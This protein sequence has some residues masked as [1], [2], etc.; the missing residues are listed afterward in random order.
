MEDI[1]K[2][3]NKSLHFLRECDLVDITLLCSKFISEMCLK[4]SKYCYFGYN[5]GCAD[6][7]CPHYQTLGRFLRI[8]LDRSCYYSA[9]NLLTKP[10]KVVQ[11]V[12]L[13]QVASINTARVKEYFGQH[14][15]RLGGQDIIGRIDETVLK[16]SV[17][18]HKK[19]VWAVTTV[20][21]S[22]V[23]SDGKSCH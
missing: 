6:Y 13:G 5:M 23:L 14:F 10:A 1:L 11:R 20:G 4:G 2:F 19:I 9:D 17:K 21:I 7:R 8:V 12:C 16:L 22:T 18:P 3:L 15:K